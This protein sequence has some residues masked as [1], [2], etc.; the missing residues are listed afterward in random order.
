M[1]FYIVF[2]FIFRIPLIPSWIFSKK[3]GRWKLKE[4]F[5]FWE[6]T[7]NS[8][9]EKLSALW[10]GYFFSFLNPHLKFNSNFSKQ[11]NFGADFHFH[12]PNWLS[13]LLLKMKGKL[14]FK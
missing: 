9:K 13:K 4:G 2:I 11:Q 12:Q 14:I 7:G 6:A 8:S 1:Y 10:K 3:L 5:L